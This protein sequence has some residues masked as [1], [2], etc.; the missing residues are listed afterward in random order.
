MDFCNHSKTGAA[1]VAAAAAGA[2]ALLRTAI[3]FPVLLTIACGPSGSPGPSA[4]PTPGN[5][6]APGTNPS[7]GPGFNPGPGSNPGNGPT[8]SATSASS[9]FVGQWRGTSEG[10][11]FTIV[12]E[13]N[14]QYSQLA[15]S[16][17]LM[18]QQSGPYTLVPPNTLIFSVTD[19]EPK[20]QQIYHPDPTGGQN[21]R[22]QQGPNGNGQNPNHPD[23]GP[24]TGGYYTPQNVPKPPG[25]TFT[26]VF[27]GPNTFTMTDQ[28]FHGSITLTRTQ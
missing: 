16:G 15:Q 11:T 12:F 9:G 22:G 5:A 10:I 26:Y 2:A 21:K 25:G 7:P 27:N 6:P 13:P 24:S 20:T 14:G 17:T 28:N 19:W 18:T 4:G 8:P 1:A 23:N 3:V